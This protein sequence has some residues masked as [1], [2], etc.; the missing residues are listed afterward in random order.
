MIT[1][2]QRA[3]LRAMANTM[4]TILH[5]GKG[6]VSEAVCLQASQALEARELIKITVLNN[7]DCTARQAAAAIAE[8]VNAEI[9]QVIGSRAVL[10]KK[11]HKN[12]QIIL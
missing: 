8:A 3:A 1:S 5:L 4:D 7:S 6:G 11:N 9:V 2:K 10:Y 12:P